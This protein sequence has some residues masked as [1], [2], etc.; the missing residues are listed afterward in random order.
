MF[1]F[2]LQDGFYALGITPADRNYFTVNVRGQ[3]YRLAGL[4][5]GWSLSPF[6]FCKM[7]LTF[8]NFLRNP[9]PEK[10]VAPT[11][12]CSKTY[13]IRARWRGARILPYV[14]D[15]LLF[16]S[17]KEE[18]LTLRHR[19][20]QLLYR[21]G[22][23]HHPTKG[24]WAP[25]QVGYHLGIDIDTSSGYF[26]APELKLTKIAQHAIHLIGRATRNAR[27]LPVN[28]LQSLAC[29]AQYLFLAI[30]AAR[31]FLHELHSVVGEKWGGLVRLTPQLRR[32]LQWWREVP[33]QSNGEPIH[34]P[35]ETACLHTD[36][37]GY[38]WGAALNEHVEA[39]GF[40]SKEDEQQHITW[41]ELKAVRQ[42]V[43]SF[44]PQL[45][46]RNVLMHEDN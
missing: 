25:A 14:Y 5:M 8:V 19:L 26:Y 9:D 1:R 29:Q 33:I 20:A 45:P 6:Y 42:A 30:P 3:L 15:F 10:H 39:R 28:D 35:I 36:S 16:A 43:E 7:T 21:L 44:L 32:D 37:S 40:W 17:T 2:Y 22:L 31:F 13:L 38:G 34:K 46:G 4:P 23:L 12:S 11:H 41:K 27:W 24:F 18:A